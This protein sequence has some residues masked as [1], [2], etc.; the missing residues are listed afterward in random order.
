MDQGLR[1]PAFLARPSP[2][3]NVAFEA[4][5]IEVSRPGPGR[6]V[7]ASPTDQDKPC[8]KQPLAGRDQ[9]KPQ[10]AAEREQD[11]PGSYGWPWTRV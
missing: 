5:E 11:K 4:Q 2:V 3:P 6:G 9:D 1:G 8:Q 10:V 7:K